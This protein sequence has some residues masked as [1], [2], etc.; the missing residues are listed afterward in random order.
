VE[1]LTHLSM[2]LLYFPT[3]ERIRTGLT[4]RVPILAGN[5]QN[6]GTLSTLGE[7]DLSAFLAS[8]GLGAISPDFVRALYPG[9]NDTNVIADSFRDLVLLCP[10]SLW[11]E[12]FV[13]SGMPDVFRYEY[14]AVFPDLQLFPN[15]GAWHSS[16]LPE[17]FGT[18]NASTAT[19][20]EVTLSNT[21]Q[22]A[23]AN[24][25]K[26]PTQSP[27]P[28]WPKYVPGPLTKTLAKL[29]Y[30][31]NV[32]LNNFVQAVTSDSQDTPCTSLWNALLDPQ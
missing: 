12:A 15:A 13:Q 10:T 18:F 11:A 9:E 4:A 3:I 1:L 14:G 28:N 5:T 8:E 17:L 20:D 27:A 30:N 31:G 19:P 25:V 32:N 2:I 29:A 22:T 6:D 21:F 7:S 16:E 24:F 26:S 23:I